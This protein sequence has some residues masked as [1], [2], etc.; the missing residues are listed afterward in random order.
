MGILKS[1]SMCFRVSTI[2]LQFRS[3]MKQIGLERVS[4]FLA[5]F[6]AL[7][8]GEGLLSIAQALN[9]SHEYHMNT[10]LTSS[11][12]VMESFVKY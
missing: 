11:N 2:Y 3:Y 10:I 5:I 7:C 9:E 1:D 4:I 8:D 12:P 6:S